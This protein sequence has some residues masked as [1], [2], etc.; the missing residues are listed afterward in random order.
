M[1][2]V[3]LSSDHRLFAQHVLTLSQSAVELLPSVQFKSQEWGGQNLDQST[4][5]WEVQW[6][7]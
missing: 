3:L 1:G 4:D 5:W 2:E 7:F 6:P